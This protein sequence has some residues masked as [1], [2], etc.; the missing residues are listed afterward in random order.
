MIKRVLGKGLEN[1]LKKEQF[2]INTK[3]RFPRFESK[4]KKLKY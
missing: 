3:D 2:L 1:Y 4:Y